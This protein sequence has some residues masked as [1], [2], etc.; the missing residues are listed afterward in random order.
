GREQRVMTATYVGRAWSCTVRLVLDDA[1]ALTPATEDLVALLH[2]VD[3]AASRF[4][5]DSAL[6]RA[7]GRAGRPTPVPALLVDLVTAALGG[8]LAV[9]GHR[10]D[11]WCVRVADR[12]NGDGPLVQLHDGGLTT[13]TT[14]VRPWLRAGRPVHHIVDPRTGRPADG[15]WPTVTV[16]APSALA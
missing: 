13:S 7:N 16:A 5:A 12:E 10:P 4:R 8:D 14:T 1:R 11:G 6:S 15:P 9:A 2:R 3:R